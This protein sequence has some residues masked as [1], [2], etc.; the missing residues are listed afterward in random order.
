VTTIDCGPRAGSLSADSHSGVDVPEM[1][2][3]EMCW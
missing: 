3:M 2:M 1:D